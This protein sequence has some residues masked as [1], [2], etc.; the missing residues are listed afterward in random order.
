MKKIPEH[1]KKVFAGEIFDVFQWDQELFDGS[2]AVFESLKRSDTV[3]VIPVTED[4]KI[5]LIEEEQPHIPLH[6]KNVAGKV[7]PGELPAETAKRELLEETGYEGK[8]VKLWYKQNLVYKIDWD[9]YTYVITGCKKVTKQNLEGGERIT[10]VLFTFE[11]FIDKVCEEDFPNLA[12][13]V[14]I[15]EAKLD[16]RKMM[17]F[18]DLLFKNS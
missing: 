12:L 10:P 17:E 8:E 16:P 11:E 15:L 5:M 6:L 14:K 2:N 1:A 7:D 4:G 18:K 13:K 9:I 3:T